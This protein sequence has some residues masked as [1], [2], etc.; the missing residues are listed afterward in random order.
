MLTDVKIPACPSLLPH[1]VLGMVSDCS[2]IGLAMLGPGK[3]SN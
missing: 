1:D 2:E 3:N